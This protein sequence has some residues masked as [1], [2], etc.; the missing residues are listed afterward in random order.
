MRRK[1]R[2]RRRGRFLNRVRRFDS[3]RGHHRKPQARGPLQAGGSIMAASVAPHRSRDG[4]GVRPVQGPVPRA[5]AQPV[6]ENSAIQL[7]SQVEPPSVENAC[8]HRAVVGVMS[9]HR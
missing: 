6:R 8:S 2:H 4:H 5:I 3:C 7:V 1:R 9:D